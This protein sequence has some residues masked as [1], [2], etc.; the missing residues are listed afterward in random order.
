MKLKNIYLL[1]IV[2][3]L[4]SCQQ[5]D[6]VDPN[7]I[8]I[9]LIVDYDQ[10]FF[11][12]TVILYSDENYL[13]K[14]NFDTYINTYPFGVLGGFEELENS[15]KADIIIHD[16]LYMSEYISKK[17]DPMYI[18]A[19]HLENGTCVVFDKNSSSD[20]EQIE[21]EEYMEGGPWSSIGGRRFYIGGKLFLDSVDLIS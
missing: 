14:T 20:I 7:R 10:N 15:V 9:D 8:S 1:I 5:D 2:I 17:N 21:M 12:K 4:I 11:T 6:E 19:H 16:T 3:V 13:I 18:L